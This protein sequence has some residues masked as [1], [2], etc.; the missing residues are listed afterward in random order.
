MKEVLEVAL[1]DTVVDPWAVVV[2]S[3]HTEAALTAV[4]SSH[5]FPGRRLAL[6]AVTRFL[7]LA[8]ERSLHAWREAAWV[9]ETSAEVGKVSH[10]AQE[11]E[12]DEVEEAAATQRNA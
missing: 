5:W 7:E 9:S 11:V 4:V 1:A 6:L 12:C 8:L 10:Q 2:H 3:E